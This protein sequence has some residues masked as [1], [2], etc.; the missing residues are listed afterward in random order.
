MP[1]CGF[2]MGF[3][4]VEMGASKPYTA[5]IKWRGEEIEA[6]CALGIVALMIGIR[7]RGMLYNTLASKTDK[8]TR[9]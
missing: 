5:R 8:N 2:H 1:P 3:P 4:T 7:F 9:P 6:F